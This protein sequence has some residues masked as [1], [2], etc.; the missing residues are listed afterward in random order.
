MAGPLRDEDGTTMVF[1]AA[2]SPMKASPA[3]DLREAANSMVAVDFVE[4]EGSTAAAV[5]MMVVA[6]T[7]GTD[8]VFGFSD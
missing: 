7:A 1:E 3:G 6:A 2:D 5:S 4:A 8:N